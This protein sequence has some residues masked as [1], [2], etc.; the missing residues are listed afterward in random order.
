MFGFIAISGFV[1]QLV[2]NSKSF[3]SLRRDRYYYYGFVVLMPLVLTLFPLA[4]NAFGPVHGL[5]FCWIIDSNREAYVVVI[6]LL[7]VYTW[8][9]LFTRYQFWFLFAWIPIAV[10][11]GF[12]TWVSIV[13]RL[14][15]L[16]QASSQATDGRGNGLKEGPVISL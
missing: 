5:P 8:W 6:A 7:N 10:L 1:F 11:V 4:Y 2:V 12:I 13:R 3:A 15:K 9:Y 16:S 14:V